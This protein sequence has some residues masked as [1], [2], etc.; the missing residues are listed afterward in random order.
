MHMAPNPPIGAIGPFAKWGTIGS[1]NRAI[2]L[3]IAPDARQS[4]AAHFREGGATATVPISFAGLKTGT[5]LC[6][7]PIFSR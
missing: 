7:L 4:D 6:I 3:R 2:S 1:H 5:H